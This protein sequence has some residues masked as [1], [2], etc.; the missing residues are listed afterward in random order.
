M[1]RSNLFSFLKIGRKSYSQNFPLVIVQHY[2]KKILS[3][4]R[5]ELENPHH[6][7]SLNELKIKRQCQKFHKKIKFCHRLTRDK[8]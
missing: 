4:Q 5:F 1:A 6:E 7:Q 8:H 3:Q 2:E